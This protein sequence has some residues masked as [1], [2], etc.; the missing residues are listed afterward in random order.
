MIPMLTS[1]SPAELDVAVAAY[2]AGVVDSDG[3]I[4]FRRDTCAMRISGL[5]TQPTYHERVCVRQIE[6]QAVDLLHAVFGG[7]RGLVGGGNQKQPLHS[8]QV[9]DRRAAAFLVA[10]L[11]HLRIKRAQALLLLEMRELK[12]VSR[13]ARF[14]NGRGVRGGGARP[15]WI[16]EE[17]ERLCNEVRLLNRVTGRFARL[18][19]D[20]PAE[21]PTGQTASTI[22]TSARSS[23]V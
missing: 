5:G 21:G 7:Y 20:R 23:A 3:T 22:D 19:A 15:A 18:A 2:S 13:A 16:S 8:W 4:G 14:A 11:P 1:D 17:M 9:V 12:V 10:V 6:P